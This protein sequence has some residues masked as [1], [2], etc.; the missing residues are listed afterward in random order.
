MRR[1]LRKPAKQKEP[2][3]K[4]LILLEPALLQALDA[5]AA[6][7]GASRCGAVRAIL[8]SVLE[9]LNAPAE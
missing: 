9:A 7:F 3:A 6:V 2:K 1:A 4:V 8:K 5:T